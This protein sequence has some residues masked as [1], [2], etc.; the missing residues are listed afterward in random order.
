METLPLDHD[1]PSIDHTPLAPDTDGARRRRALWTPAQPPADE[2][3][4]LQALWAYEIGPEP[5]PVLDELTALA[6]RLCEAPIS[7]VS[8]VDDARQWF[9]SRRGLAVGETHRDEAFCGYTI[10]APGEFLEI[11]DT[12]ADPRFEGHPMVTRAPYIRY[13]AGVPLV[14]PTGHAIGTLCV[15]D[16]TPRRLTALQRDLLQILARHALQHLE[17]ARQARSL[18]SLLAAE[19]RAADALR[20]KTAMLE[21]IMNTSVAAI[22]Q[23]SPGGDI[24]Y[25]NP[26]AEQI[27]GLTRDAIVGRTYDAPAWR[28]TAPDGGPWPADAQPFARI[29]A[30]R[31]PVWDVEHGIEWPDG[32]WRLLAINGAPILDDAGEVSSVVFSVS[33]ITERRRSEEARARL[34]TELRQ[35][36]KMQALGRLA[37]GMTHDLNNLLTIILGNVE[38]ARSGGTAGRPVEDMLNDVATAAQRARELVAQVLTSTTRQ[39]RAV[40]R[41][42]DVRTIVDEVARLMAPTLP[43]AID[44]IVDADERP[45]AVSAA[46]A[47]LHQVL[48][49]LCVNAVHAMA[50]GQGHVVIGLH[51][52]DVDGGGADGLAPGRHLSLSVSDTGIGMDAYVQ[53]RIFD[54]FFST[55]VPGEGSGL[56]LSVVQGIVKAHGGAIRVESRVGRGTTIE[57]LLPA[58]AEEP[59]CS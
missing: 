17:L 34:E 49:N 3:A 50:S 21:A 2:R 13:Y 56:G 12:R 27:L 10:L 19:Q 53:D 46:P 5:D 1:E 29:L 15:L 52:R 39:P 59:E 26:R 57:V 51:G 33:D 6:A 8:L 58:C 35:A 45:P 31:A 18:A 23:V 25:A 54:P 36:E 37:A 43:A 40:H 11:A 48:M 4:R 7:L 24:T 47:Q 9:K 14:T 16:T 28:H 20:E 44:L 41:R 22:V 30:S 32:R 42:V 38:L 55:R